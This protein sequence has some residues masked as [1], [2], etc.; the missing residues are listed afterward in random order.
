[1]ALTLPKEFED[2][3]RDSLPDYA[4]DAFL[5]SADSSAAVSVRLNPLKQVS[6]L[7][8]LDEEGAAI[9]PVEWCGDAFFLPIR[10]A[11]T[12]DPAFH[13][14]AY[15][16]QDSSSMFLSIIKD[17]ILK[18]VGGNGGAVLDLCASPGGKSTH[19][20][21]IM[22][23]SA[24]SELP[25]IVCNEVVGKRVPPLCDNIAKWGAP[26]VLVTNTSAS[27]LGSFEGFFDVILA[28]VP[29]S[30]EGMFRKSSDAVGG[31][32]RKNVEECA[33]L[34]RSIIS[35]VWPALREGG[36]LIYS[37]CTYNHF[38]N[39]DNVKFIAEELGADYIPLDKEI[40]SAMKSTGDVLVRLERGYQFVPGLVPGEGQFFAMLRKNASQSGRKGKF[41]TGARNKSRTKAR[42]RELEG[43][44]EL[45]GR[46][47]AQEAS[48]RFVMDNL[49]GEV[50]FLPGLSH[51]DFGSAMGFANSLSGVKSFG[52][53]M[54][55]VKV[56][57][58]IPDADLALS[59][60]LKNAEQ[61]S[62]HGPGGLSLSFSCTEVDRQTA[63][64]FLGRENI[65]PRPDW[66]QGYILL[67]YQGLGLGFVKNLGNRCNNLHPLMRRII[68]VR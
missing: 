9:H 24:G 65:T 63:L 14:G 55:E 18:A 45:N 21:S 54:G 15:Y 37:T 34:Q 47:G 61:V 35:D 28:D 59:S 51:F 12:L 38:E 50:Y 60:V 22:N 68:N 8:V 20:I 13:A 25:L 19:L 3:L 30:G 4:A 56:G 2:L 44:L 27:D 67:E 32:S 48:F 41:K 11:F 58:L 17:H 5:S 6:R 29:C 7:E 52:C 66:P 46:F 33:R 62:V 57:K 39:Q 43:K 16:V 26:N 10:A 40:S 36:L 42:F 23:T 53:R 1:M 31:W 64:K 49:K